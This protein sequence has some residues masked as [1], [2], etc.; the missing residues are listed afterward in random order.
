[1]TLSP[2]QFDLLL[3]FVENAGNLAAK[4]ALLDA[5]WAD[6]FVEEATLARNVSWLR[7]KLEKFGGVPYIETVPKIG[8]RFTAEVT[9]TIETENALVIEEHI[10][11]RISGEE[12]ITIEE[13]GAESDQTEDAEA[14]FETDKIEALT[15]TNSLRHRRVPSSFA[16]VAAFLLFALAAGGFIIYRE[17]YAAG[18][19]P[20]G[21]NVK[22]TIVVKDI[23]VDATQE[24]IDAGL[25]IQPGDIIKISAMGLHGHGT[26]QRFT[27]EGDET[28]K[29]SA[30]FLFPNADPYSLVAWV[31]AENE[32]ADYFQVSEN[33]RWKADSGGNLY[34]TIN[35]GKGTYMKNSGGL[36]AAVQVYRTAKISAE[37]DDYQAAWGNELVRLY[38]NDALAIRARGDVA[39]WSGGELYDLNGSDHEIEGLLA[40]S[41]NAR[42]LVGK[43]GSRTPFKVGMNFPRQVMNESGWLYLSVNDQITGKP[44]AFKN[45]SGEITVDVEVVRQPESFRNPI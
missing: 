14:I 41:V 29:A 28:F 19:K 7:K 10:V 44:D 37:D 5:V 1:M 8:Y 15:A 40:P 20:L 25:K 23:K 38:K 4:S 27:K 45:N 24:V 12:I 36:N 9:Q 42:S 21:L 17:N 43:I 26:E 11:E 30:D 22:T 35:D 18:V 32:K 16:L 3:Y 33:P 13:T 39:Y 2:K 34:L 6:S 31:G